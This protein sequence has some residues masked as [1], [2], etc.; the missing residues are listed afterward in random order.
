[1]AN[2]ANLTNP[3]SILATILPDAGTYTAPQQI[4]I[5]P[6]D[7]SNI[8]TIKRGSTGEELEYNGPFVINTTTSLIV[9]IYDS[10]GTTL[11]G[12][13]S[14]VYTIQTTPAA[15]NTP[16]PPRNVVTPSYQLESSVDVA[17]RA[18]FYITYA[19]NSKNSIKIKERISNVTGKTI[20]TNTDDENNP[21]PEQLGSLNLLTTEFRNSVNTRRLQ[22]A[23]TLKNLSG[24]VIGT[25]A[26]GKIIDY[27]QSVGGYKLSNN[28]GVKSNTTNEIVDPRGYEWCACFTSTCWIEAG[29]CPPGTDSTGNIRSFAGN[30]KTFVNNPSKT[31]NFFG[32]PGV[33]NSWVYW[34]ALHGNFYQPNEIGND[35]LKVIPGSAVIFN[36]SGGDEQHIEVAIESTTADGL[37]TAGGNTGAATNSAGLNKK[38][39]KTLFPNICGFVKP[40]PYKQEYDYYDSYTAW[41]NAVKQAGYRVSEEIKYQLVGYNGSPATLRFRRAE[42][43]N[44]SNNTV[45][46]VGGWAIGKTGWSTMPQYVSN[47]INTTG[48]GSLITPTP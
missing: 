23:I 37:V 36:R 7:F 30:A 34:G 15:S 5:T 13:Q 45:T 16:P 44:T 11:I 10:T 29:A 33:V 46:F 41:E 4:T 19:A 26:P 20:D 9:Q 42:K 2:I 38:F 6:V 3:T 18:N 32:F 21:T 43:V 39:Y 14:Y 8:I 12:N 17:R 31:L 28:N 24:A 48:L 27:F 1:M 22:S 40:W 35:P 47:G 25:L